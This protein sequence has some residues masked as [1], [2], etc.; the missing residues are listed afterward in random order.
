MKILVVSQY[1]YPE[2]FRINTLCR[3]LVLRG[4]D[5]TV[6]TGY[7]QYPGG[8]IFD[9]YGF[10]VPY[11]KNWHGVKVEHVKA[12][13]RG[14]GPIGAS[15]GYFFTCA[16]ALVSANRD[17]DT[18]MFLKTM[19]AIG[20]CFSVAFMILQLI[21][22]PGLSGVHFGKQSYILLIVWCVIGL[23]FYL[24]QRKNFEDEA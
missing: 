11:E 16:S 15:I 22:I 17:G 2:N 12:H 10:D 8:V 20:I 3:E 4:H 13:P 7:P 24:K 19:A 1:F 5:V 9:G 14:K 23:L 6:M 21:P 18:T